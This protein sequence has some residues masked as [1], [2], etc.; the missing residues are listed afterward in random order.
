MADWVLVDH[1]PAPTFLS[2]KPR[3]HSAD[4]PVLVGAVVDLVRVHRS[5]RTYGRQKRTSVDHRVRRAC[6]GEVAGDA[7]PIGPR[8]LDAD[9][10][11]LAEASQP[12]HQ[13]RVAIAVG[14]E[15]LGAEQATDLVQG[16]G[17]VDFAVGVDATGDGAR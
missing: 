2:E 4:D 17:H 9:L 16:G 10:D 14:R 3:G 11:D 12:G 6:S 8:A 13:G 15:G 5:H 7:R 1:P